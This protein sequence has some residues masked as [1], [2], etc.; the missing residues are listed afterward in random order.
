MAIRSV[1]LHRWDAA[2]DAEW[3]AARDAEWDAAREHEIEILR[4]L[5]REGDERG[6]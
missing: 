2:W 6:A 4:E 3:D 1:F 5:L